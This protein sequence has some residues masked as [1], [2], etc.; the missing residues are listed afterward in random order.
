MGM[1]RL[2]TADSKNYYGGLLWNSNVTGG[3][4]GGLSSHVFQ[5]GDNSNLIVA[6]SDGTGEKSKT[7]NKLLKDNYKSKNAQALGI[8]KK[9]M[10][11]AAVPTYIVNNEIDVVS[12]KLSAIEANTAVTSE[13]MN[14]LITGLSTGSVTGAGTG[15]F[16][17][18]LNFPKM[19]ISKGLNDAKDLAKASATI[20]TA[21]LENKQGGVAGVYTGA[22][23]TR[24]ATGGTAAITGDAPGS[25][26]F[27]NGAKPELVQSTGNMTVTP[28]NKAGSSTKQRVSRMSLAERASALSTAISSHV[29]KLSYTLPSG[30]TD[31]S[32][33]GEAIKVYDMKPGIADNIDTGNGG[34][35]TLVGLVANIYSQLA[36]IAGLAQ[37]SGTVLN[38]IAANT[39]TLNGA[40]NTTGGNPFTG[41]FPSS[42]DSILAGE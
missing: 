24:F 32:N 1:L 37:T 19:T 26:I 2:G 17:G 39:S 4:N 28:L 14:V 35:V 42:L 11:L 6:D 18:A 27:A 25:N 34:S 38:A 33:P 20:T 36:T 7:K 22:R 10:N 15:A 5:V 41:G 30:V 12:N 23:I 3:I 8:H 21:M 9:I 13:A 31:V 16:E 40:G 29:V